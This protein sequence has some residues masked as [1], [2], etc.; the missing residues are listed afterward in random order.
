MSGRFSR[1]RHTEILGARSHQQPYYILVL[2]LASKHECGHPFLRA[3]E[4]DAVVKGGKGHGV[5]CGQGGEGGM[6]QR[7]RRWHVAH[8]SR[9]TGA[10]QA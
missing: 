6:R 7:R 5:R 10:C 1:F 2:A 9:A 3:P 4:R 8:N